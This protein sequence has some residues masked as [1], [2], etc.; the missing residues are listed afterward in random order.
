MIDGFEFGL[1]Q[2]LIYGSGSIEKIEDVVK[3]LKVKGVYIISGPH[4]NKIG[5]VDK[6]AKVCEKVGVSV[7]AFTETEARCV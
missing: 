3:K 2:K 1:P 7:D 6:V 5:L 4:I